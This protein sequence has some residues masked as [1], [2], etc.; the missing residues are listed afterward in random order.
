MNKKNQNK[1]KQ[2]F[3]QRFKK[4]H[5]KHICTAC[6]A[7]I[8]YKCK[9]ARLCDACKKEREHENAMRWFK[10]LEIRNPEE[11][12]NGNLPSEQEILNNIGIRA[13]PK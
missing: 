11:I 5:S 3:I 1:I 10:K 8:S 6:G 13:T 4:E 9:R 2:K 12:V 7:D